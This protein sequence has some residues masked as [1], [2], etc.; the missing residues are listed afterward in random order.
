MALYNRN[1]KL[2]EAILE[3]PQIIPVVNRLGI[4]LGVGDSS[5]GSACEHAHTDPD[6]FLSVVNT[7]LDEDYFPANPQG[8]FTLGKTVEY[9]RK[10]AMFYRHVQLPNIE[11]HFASLLSRSGAD[12]NLGLLQKF[13]EDMKK[14][15][16]E[17]LDYDDGSLYPSL[18]R[19]VAPDDMMRSF[20]GHGE[21][22]EKLQDLLTF[23]VVHLHGDY[24][25]NLC[26]AVVTAIFSLDRDYRQN[27]RIRNRILLPLLQKLQTK[28]Q[29][30]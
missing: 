5:I 19:G 4:Y 14:Q 6:F 20:S 25:R 12:N 23:F 10:T 18:E 30:D 26:M 9:L 2:A 27:N 3:H 11:R 15:L 13:F 1:S 29:A 22:E 17:C 28:Q 24:D 16:V 7:F 8:T 21:V